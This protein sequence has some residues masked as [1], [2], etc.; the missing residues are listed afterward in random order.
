MILFNFSFIL[1]QSKR[2]Q[3]APIIQELRQVRQTVS[4]LE[5]QYT[6]KKRLYDAGM[7]NLEEE[8]G[9]I[10]KEAAVYSRD[11]MT[12]ITRYHLIQAKEKLLDIEQ[13]K[14]RYDFNGQCCMK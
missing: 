5:T 13:E 8:A 11:I 10:E 3:L 9:K 14:G 12:D 4:D 2:N 7:L 1:C 6:E